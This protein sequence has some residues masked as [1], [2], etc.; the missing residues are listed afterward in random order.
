MGGKQP[1]WI[2]GQQNNGW[3]TPPIHSVSVPPR[4]IAQHGFHRLYSGQTPS[5]TKNQALPPRLF[6]HRVCAQ[7]RGDITLCAICA[8]LP[9][10]ITLLST[11]AT[12]IYASLHANAYSAPLPPAPRIALF[13]LQRTISLALFLSGLRWAADSSEQRR[14]TGGINVGTRSHHIT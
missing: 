4:P 1:T 8:R 12:F 11:S 2:M 9:L 3:K 14:R 10:R 7:Q 5:A 6:H 13:S